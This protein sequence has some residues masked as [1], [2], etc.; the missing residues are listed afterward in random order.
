MSYSKYRGAKICFYSCRYQNQK[1]SLVSH[2][3][4]FCNTRVALVLFMQHS[5]HARVEL[6][7]HSCCSCRQCRTRVARLALVS[8]VSG[9]RVVNQTRSIIARVFF[10]ITF[11]RQFFEKESTAQKQPPDAF[12]IKRVLKNFARFTGK[13]LHWKLFLN[14]VAIL[15]KR[16]WHKCFPVDF[17]QILRTPYSHR[18]LG[19]Q[20]LSCIDSRL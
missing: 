12:I 1:F 3:C 10:L 19:R 16:L 18:S 13:H 20:L 17:A 5:C 7:L 11:A 9:T 8:L 15:K 4:R 2:S 6:V 14:K